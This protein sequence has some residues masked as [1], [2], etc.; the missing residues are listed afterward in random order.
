MKV[1][2]L[3]VHKDASQLTVMDERG[4]VQL[5]MKVATQAE[6]LRSV[7][8][9]I[10]GPKRVVFEEGPLSGMVYDAVKDLC[11]EVTSCDPAHNALIAQAEDSNDER[12]ARRLAE[13]AQLKAVRPIYVAPEPYRTLR[14]LAV[15]DHRLASNAAGIRNRIGALCRRRGVNRRGK[16]IYAG[17]QREEI[18]CQMGNGALRWQMESLYRLL[19]AVRA[20]RSGVRRVVREWAR[21]IGVIGRLDGIP[22]VGPITARTLVAW[23]ADPKRFKSR[24]ALSSY[25]GLGLG[26]GWT[27]WKPIAPARA[28]KRGNREVKRV[29]FLAAEAATK[30]NSR[31]ARR[32]E[33]RIRAG[34]KRDKAIRDLARLI[35]Q[36]ACTLW[37]K[38]LDYDDQRVTVPTG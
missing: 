11:E 27:N 19:D 29:L 12:D 1:V 32:Y 6:A 30:S 25:G 18:L 9:G 20:E 24:N 22:G 16:G 21:K 31:L 34:W 26:Q 2:S 7:I 3:D 38:G 5:E 8:G 13:L 23:I 33:A 14:S 37:R 28:S 10:G 17:R 4:E 35:L 36:I 15:H